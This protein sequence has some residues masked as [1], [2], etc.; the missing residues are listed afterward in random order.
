MSKVTVAVQPGEGQKSVSVQ[1]LKVEEGKPAEVITEAGLQVNT[2]DSFMVEEG[3]VL[4]VRD[5]QDA[6]ADKH[7]D[8]DGD[9]KVDELEAMTVAQLKALAETEAVDLG[10]ASKK[11][12]IVAAIKAA[13][14]AKAA[15]PPAT[16]EPQA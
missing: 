7:A 14:E 8:G 13:R 12:E 1:V 16:P 3:Q 5:L 6:A 10:E 9:G 15:T 11:A 2:S 4:V